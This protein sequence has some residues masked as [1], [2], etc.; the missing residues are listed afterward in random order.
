MQITKSNAPLFK[1]SVMNSLEAAMAHLGNILS[2][3]DL[4][5]HGRGMINNTLNQLGEMYGQI[6][7]ASGGPLLASL[8]EIAN[9]DLKYEREEGLLKEMNQ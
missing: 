1:G 5:P 8:I 3:D 4:S 9:A 6:Q 2:R 7:G